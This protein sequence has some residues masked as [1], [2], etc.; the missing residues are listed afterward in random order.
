MATIEQ[1]A[2]MKQT[3]RP[4]APSEVRALQFEDKRPDVSKLT[5]FAGKAYKD[6]FNK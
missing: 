2:E 3:Q 1:P 6:S 4:G 5:E